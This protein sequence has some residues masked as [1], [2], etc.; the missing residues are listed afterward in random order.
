MGIARALETLW[1]LLWVIL[2]LFPLLGPWEMHVQAQHGR[3]PLPA[4][5]PALQ[6]PALAGCRR[7]NRRTQR[8]SM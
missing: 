8:V 6:R 7:Q 1:A 3:V 5:R 2:A 4:L